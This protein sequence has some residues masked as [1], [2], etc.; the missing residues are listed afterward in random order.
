MIVTILEREFDE[1]KITPKNKAFDENEF[2]SYREFLL[3]VLETEVIKMPLKH[4][5]ER[6]R[7]IGK[8]EQKKVLLESGFIPYSQRPTQEP[9]KMGAGK[10]QKIYKIW[11]ND[12]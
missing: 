11:T 6:M 9:Q 5:Y 2:E 10:P 8:K 7:F 4:A 12:S 1:E 3:A